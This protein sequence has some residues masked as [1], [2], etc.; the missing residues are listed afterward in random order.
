MI[1]PKR[2]AWRHPA[3]APT[4]TIGVTISPE[5]PGSRVIEVNADFTADAYQGTGLSLSADP[6]V[7][8]PRSRQ[9]AESRQ[10]SPTW[11]EPPHA[12]VASVATSFTGTTAGLILPDALW[13]ASITFSVPCPSASGASL[14]MSRTL[15]TNASGRSRK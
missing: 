11:A 5:Q 13:T 15:T 12:R 2:P 7:P 10:V 9:R 14:P 4:N 3:A 6:M 1:E 8:R